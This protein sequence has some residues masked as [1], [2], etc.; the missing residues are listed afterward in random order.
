MLEY[1]GIK[2]K[3]LG[4]DAFLLEKD[5]K[6]MIDPYRLS[7][8]IEAD[9]ILLSHDHFDHMSA[10][11]LEK[12]SSNKTII[13]AAKECIDKIGKLQCKEKIS[14]LPGEEKTVNG[15]KIKGIAAYNIN[16]INPDTK[17]PFHPKEDNKIGF[18]INMGNTIIYHTGDSDLV[19]EMNNLQPDVLLV[20]VSG[21]Y[22]M[23]A[24]EAAQAVNAIKPKIAIPMHFGTIVGSIQDAQEFKNAVT[25]CE[26]H[27]PTKEP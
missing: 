22:V 9:M 12:V 13:V 17:K 7:K 19:P 25:R 15:I 24:G 2:I 11:D 14:L 4:H 5:L 3:W 18:L 23:T 20:P 1:K 26:V 27:I 10:E 6:I 16:K 8:Y 21:T